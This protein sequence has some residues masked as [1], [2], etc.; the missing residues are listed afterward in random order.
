MTGPYPT[1]TDLEDQAAIEI[2]AAG[3]LRAAGKAQRPRQWWP[4]A[5]ASSWR[6][7]PSQPRASARS[8][9]V[10]VRHEMAVIRGQNFVM[11]G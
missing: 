3:S 6:T 8:P 10:G 2:G 1:R 7:L 4:I 5:A 11:V 9:C